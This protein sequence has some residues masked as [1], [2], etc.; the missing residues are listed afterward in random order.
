MIW[1]NR[2]DDLLSQQ[3]RAGIFRDALGLRRAL[4]N[5][6]RGR[7]WPL[8]S[9]ARPEMQERPRRTDSAMSK[10]YVPGGKT[11]PMPMVPVRGAL[12]AGTGTRAPSRLMTYSRVV[13]RRR[14]TLDLRA[15]SCSSSKT[16]RAICMSPASASTTT[17]CLC[18]RPVSLALRVMLSANLSRRGLRAGQSCAEGIIAA[19]RAAQ[20]WRQNCRPCTTACSERRP[21]AHAPGMRSRR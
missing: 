1:T 17:S 9:D 14:R 13:F 19:A 21:G 4:G 7:S 2:H 6:A 3:A 20:C 15:N 16:S 12:C 5:D 10:E 11:Y 18:C 8:P